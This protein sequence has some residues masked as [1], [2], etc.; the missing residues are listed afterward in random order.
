MFI[1]IIHT[2]YLF[3]VDNSYFKSFKTVYI[4]RYVGTAF[5]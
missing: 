2:K 4:G 1:H 5:V 3:Y